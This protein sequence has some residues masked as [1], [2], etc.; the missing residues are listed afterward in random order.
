[1]RDRGK[2]SIPKAHLVVIHDG[3]SSARLTT[4]D[5]R[6]RIERKKKYKKQQ[7]AYL[8]RSMQMFSPSNNSSAAAEWKKRVEQG[9]IL[10]S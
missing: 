10:H 2:T 3:V 1:M 7:H 9:G 8:Q 5:R 4:H 6:P